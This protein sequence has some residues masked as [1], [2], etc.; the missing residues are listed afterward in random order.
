[1]ER[2]LAFTKNP[3]TNG[4]DIAIQQLQNSDV[5]YADVSK[6]TGKQTLQF[7]N[8]N[9]GIVNYIEQTGL[10]LKNHLLTSGFV[11]YQDLINPPETLA[12]WIKN[13]NIK[14]TDYDYKNYLFVETLVRDGKISELNCGSLPIGDLIMIKS[15][16]LQYFFSLP[17]I[18]GLIDMYG[19]DAKLS[20]GYNENS[21]NSLSFVIEGNNSN[22]AYDMSYD[23]PPAPSIQAGTSATFLQ[24]QLS[25][26]I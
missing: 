12:S 6:L 16:I 4:F 1:M 15:S 10:S 7:I 18:K 2:H 19:E 20:F 17:F 22:A 5:S 14:I 3:N 21:F 8:V 13:S 24:E 11:A 23:P 25:L 9:I 26:Y